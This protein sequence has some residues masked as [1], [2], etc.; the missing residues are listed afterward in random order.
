MQSRRIFQTKHVLKQTIDLFRT[1]RIAD[2][3]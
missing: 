1:I 2:D 3:S